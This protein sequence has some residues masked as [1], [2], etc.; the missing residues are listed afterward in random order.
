MFRSRLL[1]Q[2][3]LW[4]LLLIVAGSTFNCNWY[5]NWRAKKNK[6]SPTIQVIPEDANLLPLAGSLSSP[7]SSDGIPWANGGLG[8][9]SVL[10]GLPG[11]TPYGV[12]ENEPRRVAPEGMLMDLDIIY[13]SYDSF[14]LTSEMKEVLDRAAGWLSMN[15]GVVIQIEGHCDERGTFEYNMNLGQ[16][17]ADAVREYLVQ[18]GINADRLY[19]ISYG[20]ERPLELGTSNDSFSRNRRVQFLAYGE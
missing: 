20:E 12:E 1:V 4:M 8:T 7:G 6:K 5:K 14:T 15:S 13:F 16:K 10:G 9:G 11:P 2:L 18:K 19:T 3:K 17:R